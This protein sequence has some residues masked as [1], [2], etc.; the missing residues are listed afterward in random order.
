LD[1]F[2]FFHWPTYKDYIRQEGHKSS[3]SSCALVLALSAL[4]AARVR[5]QASPSPLDSSL[6]AVPAEAWSKACFDNLP[7]K[8][9]ASQ[10]YRDS[11]NYMRTYAL[12][13][14]LSVQNAD[15][16]NFQTNLGRYLTLSAVHCFH[17]EDRWSP[18]LS[19]IERDERRRLVRENGC[20]GMP[21]KR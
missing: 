18:H 11:F 5:D 1:S 14:I 7:R 16:V 17:D 12:L 13:A 9:S 19:E 10:D 3:R 4:A 20:F 8:H 6:A 15:L 2:P 21:A